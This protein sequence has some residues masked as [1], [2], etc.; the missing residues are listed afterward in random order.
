MQLI[1]NGQFSEVSEINP[2]VAISVYKLSA[3]EYSQTV[4]KLLYRKYQSLLNNL[5]NS[6]TVIQT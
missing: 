5:H 3:S 2:Y 6:Q 1:V 4:I